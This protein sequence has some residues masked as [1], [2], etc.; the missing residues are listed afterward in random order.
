MTDEQLRLAHLAA[1]EAIA[2]S[3]IPAPSPQPQAESHSEAIVT[4]HEGRPTV[5]TQQKRKWEVFP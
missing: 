3:A 4:A 2:V 5:A 1:C